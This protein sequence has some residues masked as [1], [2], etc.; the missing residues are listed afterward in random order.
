MNA[1]R[2]ATGLRPHA[3]VRAAGRGRLER[4]ALPARQTYRMSFTPFLPATV[5]FGPLRVRALVRVR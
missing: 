3:I 2:Y 4:Q 1:I 5:F